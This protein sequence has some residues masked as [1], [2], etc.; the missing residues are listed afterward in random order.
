[1]SYA[2]P[3][4]RKP[5]RSAS[6]HGRAPSRH[7]KP[8]ARRSLVHRPA[9][10]LTIA[11]A[12]TVA[13]GAAAA[14]VTFLPGKPRTVP[15]E[16]TLASSTAGSGSA[17]GLHAS[18]LTSSLE[19]N[20]LSKSSYAAKAAR[21]NSHARNAATGH[22]VAAVKK[23]HHRAAPPAAPLYLNPLRAVA[24]LQPQRIDMG[25]DF[26]G[27]GPI[28]PI[29]DAVITSAMGTSSGWPGGGWITYQLTDGPAAG[30]VVYLAEDVRPTAA[31]GEKVTPTTEIASMFNGYEGIETGWA[32]PDSAS[33]ESQLPEAGG[34]GGSGP[35]PTKVGVSFD[36]LLQALGVP[37]APNAGQSAY[38]LLPSN[39]LL[40]WP[41]LA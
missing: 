41:G 20:E 22:I 32:M 33:A 4:H 14:A 40:T 27:S 24:G 16:R 36:D 19:L 29:G 26:G 7:R 10:A 1:V 35:F 15:P 6:T 38:G 17:A 2:I 11:A 31:V 25:A 34:I 21:A 37:A 9:L 3:R 8:Q 13:G 18:A 39:Y 28:Y 23:R 5:P 12:V 30:L